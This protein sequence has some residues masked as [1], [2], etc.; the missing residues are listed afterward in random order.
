MQGKDYINMNGGTMNERT[1][2]NMRL[3]ETR[4][5]DAHLG[6]HA[7]GLEIA[8]DKAWHISLPGG[9]VL[10]VCAHEGQDCIVQIRERGDDDQS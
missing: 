8:P 9:L 1:L 5:L 4:I 10:R 3:S 6:D 2:V 7:I